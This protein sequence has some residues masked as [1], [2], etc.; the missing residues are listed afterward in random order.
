[1]IGRTVHV[2]A[3]ALSAVG[4]LLAPVVRAEPS[5]ATIHVVESGETLSQIALDAGV[6]TATL[7]RLN[8]LQDTDLLIVGQSLKLP[9]SPAAPARPAATSSSTS[10]YTVADGDTL[11]SIAE[12]FNTTTAALVEANHLED[13]DRLALGTA[14][15]VPG[16]RASA[17]AVATAP[18][19]APAAR[20]APAPARS[21]AALS[22]K[23]IMVPYTVQPGETLS[24]IAKQ[25]D[26]RSDA[27]AQASGVDDPNRIVIGTVL[28]VPL[29]GYEHIVKAGETLRDI[30]AQEKVDLGSLVDFNE[31]DDPSLIRV[32]QVVL[33]PAPAPNQQAATAPTPAPTPKP[34]APP[35][36]AGNAAPPRPAAAAPAPAPKPV[37]VTARP[38]G[39]PTEGIAGAGLKLLGAP[40]VWGGSSPSGFDC[41]GFVWYAARQAGKSISRGMLG[42]YNSGPHP[43]R[44]ELKAGDLVFFQNTYTPGLSH[45]GIYIGN[46]QF[47]HAA[48][49]HAG[50]TI[51]SL[52]SAYW[53]SPWVG[54]TRLP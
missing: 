32:G 30:A 51:S 46:G 12:Q 37:A 24:Q 15:V 22:A 47:V 52:S 6:D 54:A 40:Y 18:A 26:V 21:P 45:N 42:E 13:A 5:A 17:P 4:L 44:D 27:I 50:V 49:E 25:F 29:P 16:G 53:S 8:D 10:T 48:D 14:L 41:S 36:A 43:S 39:A 1:M 9:N 28:K 33:V 38:P 19:P 20:P 34:S 2:L 23:R 11:W 7:A 31:L 35:A 3:V